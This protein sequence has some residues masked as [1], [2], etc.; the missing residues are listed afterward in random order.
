MLFKCAYLQHQG[1][2][3]MLCLMVAYKVVGEILF[4]V[5]VQCTMTLPILFVMVF[6][7]NYH[8]YVM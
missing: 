4:I 2:E 7:Q 6:V 1:C 8:V 3:G 5:S